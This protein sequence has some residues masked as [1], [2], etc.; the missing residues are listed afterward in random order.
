MT[1]SDKPRLRTRIWKRVRRVI[2]TLFVIQTILVAGLAIYIALGNRAGRRDAEQVLADL[3]TRGLPVSRAEIYGQAD[4]DSKKAGHL[5]SA[6]EEIVEVDAGKYEDLPH[7][8]VKGQPLALCEPVGPELIGKLRTFSQ[9]HRR[10]FAL[11]DELRRLDVRL[12]LAD[13]YALEQ[14]ALPPGERTMSLA[15]K[16]LALSLL[17]QAEGRPGDAIRLCGHMASL[18]RLFDGQ[19]SLLVALC[20]AGVDAAAQA[21]IEEAL[22]RTTPKPQD[23]R[24]VQKILLAEDARIDLQEMYKGEMA[25]L[26]EALADPELMDLAKARDVHAVMLA[27]SWA[28]DLRERFQDL[29]RDSRVTIPVASRTRV[30]LWLGVYWSWYSVCPG[31]F[32][33]LYARN[34]RDSIA[35]H[36]MVAAPLPA[37]ARQVKDRFELEKDPEVRLTLRGVQMILRG[38]ACVRVAIVALAVELYRIEHGK[39]PEKLA[40]VGE[41]LPMDPFTGEPMRYE[42]TADGRLIYS[43]G[44]DLEDD[45]G[46]D[47]RDISDDVTFRLFDPDR[48]NKPRPPPITGGSPAILPGPGQDALDPEALEATTDPRVRGV[49]ETTEDDRAGGE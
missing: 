41:S 17:A 29:A 48:R 36:E 37:P 43:I 49:R 47:D 7:V 26:A 34:I 5:L 8:G 38:K 25:T 30:R 4:P 13:L 45:G 46:K 28:E 1:E 35:G 18:N 11:L 40:D 22:S 27:Q 19:P 12:P 31:A 14:P 2:V 9:D 15:R 3:R 32:Q 6:A 16:Y 23:L 39:W 44:M 20:Q 10:Y 33:S 21:G 42:P 24:S